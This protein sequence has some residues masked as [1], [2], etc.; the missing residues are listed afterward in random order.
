MVLKLI[1]KRLTDDFYNFQEEDK[2]QFRRYCSDNTIQLD[3]Q[4][5]R[6]QAETVQVMIQRDRH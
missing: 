2:K 3:L 6:E 5:R 4:F 1:P